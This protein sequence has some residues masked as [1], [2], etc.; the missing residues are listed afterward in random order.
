MSDVAKP[1]SDEEL[2]RVLGEYTTKAAD[3]YRTYN[4]QSVAIMALALAALFG[5]LSVSLIITDF[6][7]LTYLLFGPALLAVV[8]AYFY[9]QG[10]RTSVELAAWH[11]RRIYQLVSRR[12]D[13]GVRLDSGTRLELEL[14]L[15]E[16]GFLLTQM[17]RFDR[18]EKFAPFRRVGPESPFRVLEPDDS[19]LRFADPPAP[20]ASIPDAP[21]HSTNPA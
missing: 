6:G 10:T 8:V 17:K 13:I 14:R 11:L 18:P 20:P 5:L 2:I 7:A 12:E 3:A 15:S 21:N 4:T 9:L 1:I 16:A 19:L